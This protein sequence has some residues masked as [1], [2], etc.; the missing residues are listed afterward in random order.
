MKN[1]T[2]RILLIIIL[3]NSIVVS[4][5][6]YNTKSDYNV[7]GNMYSITYDDGDQNNGLMTEFLSSVN[8]SSSG[9][10]D[11]PRIQKIGNTLLTRQYLANN[12]G[13]SAYQVYD[14]WAWHTTTQQ[15]CIPLLPYI[16]EAKEYYSNTPG[17]K[18][19]SNVRIC[20]SYIPKIIRNL[21]SRRGTTIQYGAGLTWENYKK[22]IKS[23]NTAKIIAKLKTHKDKVIR[24]DFAKYIEEQHKS[25]ISNPDNKDNYF[26]FIFHQNCGSFFVPNVTFSNYRGILLNDGSDV[27]SAAYRTNISSY[28]SKALE[29]GI[30]SAWGKNLYGTI[31][32]TFYPYGSNAPNINTS[33]SNYFI[34]NLSHQP[35][36]PNQEPFSIKLKGDVV[37]ISSNFNEVY[38]QQCMQSANCFEQGLKK[39]AGNSK[40]NNSI[41]ECIRNI[42]TTKVRQRSFCEIKDEKEAKYTFTI[43]KS[44]FEG[45]DESYTKVKGVSNFK[46]KVKILKTVK[47]NEFYVRDDFGKIAEGKYKEKLENILKKY[48]LTDEEKAK[49]PQNELSTSKLLK[50]NLCSADEN[51]IGINEKDIK[52]DKKGNNIINN[53]GNY[54]KI[55]EK[56]YPSKKPYEIQ[57]YYEC[58][59]YIPTVIEEVSFCVV[60]EDNYRFQIDP[61][62]ENSWNSVLVDQTKDPFT[63]PIKAKSNGTKY[64]RQGLTY[65]IKNPIQHIV[66]KKSKGT[67]DRVKDKEV[68]FGSKI[69]LALKDI[70]LNEYQIETEYECTR[71]TGTCVP[72][73]KGTCTDENLNLTQTGSIEVRQRTSDEA[74][75]EIG[76]YSDTWRWKSVPKSFGEVKANKYSPDRSEEIWNASA[77][78][79]HD[80]TAFVDIGASLFTIEA[81][82][83]KSNMIKTSM[84]QSTW[85]YT[86]EFKDKDLRLIGFNRTH[87]DG[88]PSACEDGCESK[89]DRISPYLSG[90]YEPMSACSGSYQVEEDFC[91]RWVSDGH[92]GRSC[93]A[94]SCR[95]GSVTKNNRKKMEVRYDIMKVNMIN[96]YVSAVSVNTVNNVNIKL[97][98]AEDNF[99]NFSIMANNLNASSDKLEKGTFELIGMPE[100]GTICNHLT[101]CER[102][103]EWNACVVNEI[104]KRYKNKE[105]YIKY[106]PPRYDIHINALNNP[107]LKNV[108]TQHL[109]YKLLDDRQIIFTR[110]EPKNDMY[111]GYDPGE[112]ALHGQLDWAPDFW[113]PRV[114]TDNNPS[115]WKYPD[116]SDRAT[117]KK[118]EVNKIM[119][120]KKDPSAYSQKLGANHYCK[121]KTIKSRIQGGA[122]EDNNRTSTT[123]D[124]PYSSSA[125]LDYVYEITIT[126][127]K[128][129]CSR[130]EINEKGRISCVE[131][132]TV[133]I[134][135]HTAKAYGRKDISRVI[136][137]LYKSN[138]GE[139]ILVYYWDVK[140]KKVPG[141]FT[142]DDDSI[143]AFY[144]PAGI[145]FED[146]VKATK[147]PFRTVD[148][149]WSIIKQPLSNSAIL[150]S[151][152]WV[153]EIQD[154]TAAMRITTV[155]MIPYCRITIG[156][157]GQ[158]TLKA[159]KAAGQKAFTRSITKDS[160]V[161]F[162]YPIKSISEYKSV[163]NAEVW[164]AYKEKLSK[165]ENPCQ[166]I[167]DELNKD[168]SHDL[169]EVDGTVYIDTSHLSDLTPKINKHE[170]FGDI[171]ITNLEE[172]T[173][174]ASGEKL[175][176]CETKEKT[177]Y[178]S[179]SCEKTFFYADLLNSDATST[180]NTSFLPVNEN[181]DEYSK[182]PYGGYN[183][184]FDVSSI[185]RNN[186][187]YNLFYQEGIKVDPNDI[188]NGIRENNRATVQYKS[189]LREGPEAGI[190]GILDEVDKYDTE[191]NYS[192]N[193]EGLN[194]IIIHTPVAISDVM[195]SPQ[196]LRDHRI[197][198]QQR[199]K[200]V[201]NPDGVVRLTPATKF[202]LQMVNQFETSGNINADGI[203]NATND[204]GINYKRG[205]IIDEAWVKER[206]VR[207][208]V[209]VISENPHDSG[210]YY[211]KGTA[212]PIDGTK[213]HT[214]YIPVNEDETVYTNDNNGLQAWIVASNT[215][216]DEG[217]PDRYSYDNYERRDYRAKH[218]AYF[219]KGVEVVG[220]IGNF[221]WNYTTDPQWQNYFRYA[222]NNGAEIIKGFVKE[223]LMT[224]QR[225]FIGG[226]YSMYEALDK[227]YAEGINKFKA[228]QQ[229][230]NPIYAKQNVVKGVLYNQGCPTDTIRDPLD[231]EPKS[232][233]A[234]SDTPI[235][236]GYP[237]Y[238]TF[239]SVGNYFH[240]NT[241]AYITP[242]YYLIDIPTD[243]CK[244]STGGDGVDRFINFN[245][246]PEDKL[247]LFA[248][249]EGQKYE[250]I[251]NQF[252]K[253]FMWITKVEDQNFN[254]KGDNE[255]ST[256]YQG[257]PKRYDIKYGS[258]W[259][260]SMAFNQV[261]TGIAQEGYGQ[262][263]YGMVKI[264][265]SV[266]F[267]PD[268]KDNKAKRNGTGYVTGCTEDD[269]SKCALTDEDLKDKLIL[270]KLRINELGP[271]WSLS[272]SSSNSTIPDKS[273]QMITF[274]AD[275]NAAYGGHNRPRPTGKT[276]AKNI[277]ELICTSGEPT[278]KFENWEKI[279]NPCNTGDLDKV[280]PASS[281]YD[282]A[283]SNRDKAIF[284]MFNQFE[285]SLPK[286][287]L[288]FDFIDSK[289][290]YK[291]VITNNDT[292]NFYKNK[293]QFNPGIIPSR[294]KPPQVE[295]MSWSTMH[296]EKIDIPRITDINSS[297][298]LDQDGYKD[299]S[300]V[301]ESRGKTIYPIRPGNVPE[302]KGPNAT[303]DNMSNAVSP[304][305]PIHV[306]KQYFIT[307][308]RM[309]PVYP[310]VYAYAVFN[311][312]IP[313]NN[314]P[315]LKKPYDLINMLKTPPPSV[316]NDE[317]MP[318]IPPSPTEPVEPWEPTFPDTG[319]PPVGGGFDKPPGTD[320]DEK[321]PTPDV[322]IPP[323]ELPPFKPP[324][325]PEPKYPPTNIVITPPPDITI[326]PDY[327][328]NVP[329][330]DYPPTPG[331]VFNPRE[332]SSNDITIRGTW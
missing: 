97:P 195:I 75:K 92:G 216:E 242:E 280:T 161:S 56:K 199:S 8:I 58:K 224:S 61:T 197:Y 274:P 77:G 294:Q 144:T 168:L 141:E 229:G 70:K 25:F 146:Y 37:N 91:C 28:N 33:F 40:F 313:K 189:V 306:N 239:Q 206:W 181:W 223:P 169:K 171:F 72:S 126:G 264:P 305:T 217:Y 52:Q 194:D 50:A 116:I 123:I 24:E 137:N 192:K 71:K 227:S 298:I 321:P 325:V 20:I 30:S 76:N 165:G 209:G 230:N 251:D 115:E 108:A 279:V 287:N 142:T 94:Y 10:S 180:E 326:P 232:P 117:F 99:K 103:A 244:V 219:N 42:P 89:G 297:R 78:M 157:A 107:Y 275:P 324:V 240:P 248:L 186:G 120:Y 173:I 233:K 135:P 289:G 304:I 90:E 178:C 34:P 235:K 100:Q 191:S 330:P 238:F 259:F 156:K 307:G 277:S 54:I 151:N 309:Q 131:D 283:K 109:R 154:G 114:S 170:M 234:I 13:Q 225:Y 159:A 148:Y 17:S 110:P 179:G 201:D 51:C 285:T 47:Q 184:N 125:K 188:V 226:K 87:K 73:V 145:A 60:K 266:K 254:L 222:N 66:F 82:S 241:R 38:R 104:Y 183:G 228:I 3:I 36:I 44:W 288:P 29:R 130:K 190:R 152:R 270:V 290:D 155:E 312:N 55:I 315:S 212:I 122:E 317:Y 7:D 322:T 31:G 93:A 182:L 176:I 220:R 246:K 210:K 271:I 167:I 95:A 257:K 200:G 102:E 273:G 140:M 314:P 252:H 311:S 302:I 218:T 27:N 119:S 265:S 262:R 284:S 281:T 63:I 207:L 177:K 256:D 88:Q 138:F 268:H 164:N 106:T 231:V 118:Y 295:A 331:I 301:R 272:M 187:G 43:Q 5:N 198:A 202:T 19:D 292:S 172:S 163:K 96:N 14:S 98:F 323:G 2:K 62:K 299:I 247:K 111:Q 46:D 32:Q 193:V 328:I 35:Y 269:V 11:Y 128:K 250:R 204:K 57:F 310:Y 39:Y 213:V 59:E 15:F 53:L 149:K 83:P 16:P 12:L 267:I 23:L 158:L 160:E 85:S 214:Y 41:E 136:S 237:I 9:Q 45:R 84:E 101:S 253:D 175:D 211:P 134:D 65:E 26:N 67:T 282:G 129:Y 319:T 64:V 22:W 245:E 308:Y 1:I 4:S 293:P 153:T 291:H 215:P 208:P 255:Y 260:A 112:S 327:P 318:Y 132:K 243:N 49:F 147:V 86:H 113:V 80:E 81:Q 150:D 249:G 261:G 236:I 21:G 162:D 174:E 69:A 286:T 139:A 276:F 166:E 105:I 300:K 316:K 205:L 278:T 303:Y 133:V 203:E 124:K 48:K 263:W 258:N 18:F 68:P 296:P 127:K 320:E 196:I 74:G 143:Q 332:K 329:P 6:A 121:F 185:Q 79:P 221:S